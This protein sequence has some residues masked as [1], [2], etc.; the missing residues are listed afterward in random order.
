MATVMLPIAATEIGRA[1]FSALEAQLIEAEQ[2]TQ[3]E[4]K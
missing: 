4:A 2:D 1:L 3:L